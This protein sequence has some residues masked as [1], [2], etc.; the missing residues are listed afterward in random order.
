MVGWWCRAGIMTMIGA[1]AASGLVVTTSVAKAAVV[2]A[3]PAWKIRPSP[4][5]TRP[6]GE[7]HS[8]S[9]S[10][11]DAC[12]AVG[13]YI[14]TAGLNVTL[15]E[16]WNGSSW[17][18][19]AT[20]NPSSDM[21]I[22]DSPVLQGVSCP[23]A[24]FCETVGASS[25]GNIDPSQTVLADLWDGRSWH[26]QSV[27]LP[28][29]ATS[30]GLDAVSCTSA[31][32][33]IA[34][35]S[36]ADTS[37]LSALA[38]RWNGSSWHLQSTP[39]PA[40]S[41]VGLQGVACPTTIRCEAVGS[42]N[43]NSSGTDVGLAEVWDGSSWQLQAMPA[44]ALVTALSCTSAQFC[45]AVGASVAAGW[46]G[47][48]WM[49]QN[50]PA[51]A[52][53]TLSGVS[54]VSPVSCEAVG[55]NSDLTVAAGWNGTSWKLQRTKN[56]VGG[57]PGS[58]T[59]NGF[60]A[61]SCTD[62][63]NCEAG[64]YFLRADSSFTEP[65][66]RALAEVWNG[67]SWQIQGAAQPQGGTTNVLD[68]VSCASATFC[69]AVGWRFDV[70]EDQAGLAEVWNG[71]R[72][73]LQKV[74]SPAQANG[75]RLVLTGVSC[76]SARFCEAVGD[77]F[78][79]SNALIWNGK[80][81]TAQFVPH[82][83]HLASVSCTTP[84]FCVAVGQG[85]AVMWD[86]HAWS[87]LPTDI[88]FAYNSVSCLS[89]HFCEATGYPL[90]GSRSYAE[91]WNGTSWSRQATPVPAGATNVVLGSVSCTTA[92]SCE[93]VG[94]YDSTSLMLAE[95]WNGTV[96]TIQHPPRPKAATSAALTGVWCTSASF[97]AAVGWANTTP[98]P[99]ALVWDGTAW[100]LRSTAS[101][102]PSAGGSFSGVWC[103]PSH[104]CTGVGS[105][106]YKNRSYSASTLVETGN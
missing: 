14:S 52:S 97:C 102:P 57:T 4:N 37:G 47:T 19:Q 68:A 8:I 40:G 20:P 101:L 90:A 39:A 92:R 80:T 62:A 96:W 11:A 7:I 9:C 99:L 23:S 66:R 56:P 67:T 64:G 38:E 78:S 70:S 61:V 6:G 15:A 55:W 59:F 29:G 46:N 5:F 72:W 22:L 50:A 24:D 88:A 41:A 84:S 42:Y 63:K 28:A 2:T 76:V 48:S 54:C 69:E 73:R 51:L 83:D 27:P 16:R 77:S 45:E 12:T 36:Y 49:T 79:P 74:P 13:T 30:A 21:S 33:C 98:G 81:W 34:V 18:R 58:T 60:Y 44:S 53:A 10:S 86:G 71:T 32:F 100:N 65:D 35:G 94:S 93:A 87:N 106:G 82:P 17:T 3:K 25:V 31:K 43:A 26:A 95:R 103:R 89:V 104:T 91:I 105:L 85:G 75:L 1:C